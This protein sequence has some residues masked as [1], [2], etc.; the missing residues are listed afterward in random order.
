MRRFLKKI[1]LMLSFLFIWNIFLNNFSFAATPNI[2]TTEQTNNQEDLAV[3]LKTFQTF[4]QALYTIT[5]PLVVISWKFMD[6]SVIYGSF[7]WMDTLLWHVWN[8]MRTFANYIIWFILIFSIF[9]LFL[10]WKLEQFNPIKII[11]QLAIAAVLVNASWFLIWVMIDIS[12]VMTYAVGTLP[13]QMANKKIVDN[14]TIPQFWMKLQDNGANSFQVWIMDWNKL[15]PFC[16]YKA[17]D[18]WELIAKYDCAFERNWKYYNY[19]SWDN[20][21][22]TSWKLIQSKNTFSEIQKKLWWMTWILWTMYASLINIWA[23]VSYPSWSWVA[24]IWDLIFKLFFL[25]ALIIPL[26]TLAVILIVRAVFL[27]MFIII[28]PIIFLFTPIKSFEKVLWEKGKLTNLVSLIFLPVVVVFALSLSFVFLSYLKFDEGSIKNTFWVDLNSKSVVIPLDWEDGNHKITISYK[29]NDSASLFANMWNTFTWLIEN[30][31]AIA[32]MW[33]VV[34]SVFK[35]SKLTS[36]IASSINKFSVSM[37]KATPIVPFAGWQS[38]S[39]LWQGLQQVKSL[40]LGRQKEQYT[41]KIQPFIDE[42]QSKMSWAE[43]KNIQAANT[44]IPK[45]QIAG[46]ISVASYGNSISQ[47]NKSFGNKKVGEL[48]KNKNKNEFSKLAAKLQINE[49]TLRNI[50]GRQDYKDKKL[51]DIFNDLKDKLKE[52]FSKASKEELKK[53]INTNVL[54]KDITLLQLDDDAKDKIKDFFNQ[55]WLPVSEIWRNEEI[56]KALKEIWFKEDEIIKLL[57]DDLMGNDSNAKSTLSVA[58]QTK[59]KNWFNKSLNSKSDSNQSGNNNSGSNTSNSSGGNSN[60]S[61][62]NS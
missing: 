15:L 34:F 32:F 16:E 36:W 53:L 48:L 39:S 6:N 7:I 57:S 59:I 19:N 13:L 21:S 20:I 49:T 25:L 24:M 37:A 17:N 22:T 12:N 55:V 26:L 38:I 56:V 42:M 43:Q 14:Q 51:K 35:T 46:W 11:P 28:S 52:N 60:K 27:W 1:I 29:W 54:S 23:T 5:W 44:N 45:Q 9:T 30:I 4:W 50:L 8:V 47:A 61:G 2:N 41:K 40:P 62:T 3:K 18:K 10:W 33:I 58:D 31:F